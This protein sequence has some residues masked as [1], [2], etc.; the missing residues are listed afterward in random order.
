MRRELERIP[1]LRFETRNGKDVVYGLE[2]L[3]I[4]NIPSD[5]N[6]MVKAA[7]LQWIERARERNAG[8]T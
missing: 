1:G 2:K 5:I 8:N 4:T 6:P 3:N 7:L